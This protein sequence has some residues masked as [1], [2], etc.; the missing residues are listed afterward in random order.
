VT[1]HVIA[2]ASVIA[3]AFDPVR[4]LVAAFRPAIAAQRAPHPLVPRRALHCQVASLVP[5]DAQR[6][7]ATILATVHV[8][9]PLQDLRASGEHLHGRHKRNQGTTSKPGRDF[10]V[11]LLLSS[12]ASRNSR[13]VSKHGGQNS[14]LKV[15]LLTIPAYIQHETIGMPNF[16]MP[17]LDSVNHCTSDFLTGTMVD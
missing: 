6:L 17:N 14:A 8:L 10:F 5:T 4:R 12:W 7:G 2:L 9:A 16:E 15:F 13:N 3:I 11:F 1:L